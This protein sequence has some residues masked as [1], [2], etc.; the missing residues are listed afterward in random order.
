MQTLRF[1]R[2]FKTVTNEIEFINQLN[3]TE[4]SS[5]LYTVKNM[6]HNDIL[7]VFVSS[8]FCGLTAKTWEISLNLIKK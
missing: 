5:I 6:K 7:E 4:K 8:S 3:T 1:E 2:P